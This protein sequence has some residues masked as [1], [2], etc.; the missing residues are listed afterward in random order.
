[1]KLF[2]GALLT[3]LVISA[4]R[5]SS[6]AESGWVWQNPLPQG[7]YLFAVATPGPSTVV[8]LGGPGIIVRTTDGGASWRAQDNPAAYGFLGVSFVDA[9]TG[10]VAGI[11]GT[12]L[13]TTTRGESRFPYREPSPA[14][15]IP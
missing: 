9:N 10:T 4:V 15:G 6:F 5:T 13:R 8:A 11:G 2:R 12:I 3:L 1:M 7:N 14:L